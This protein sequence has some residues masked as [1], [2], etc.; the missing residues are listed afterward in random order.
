MGGYNYVII[1]SGG[2]GWRMAG[3]RSE[4]A[5]IHYVCMVYKLAFWGG[6]VRFRLD[7]LRLYIAM[8]DLFIH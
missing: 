8:S 4:K 7:K 6:F 2:G 5:S 1:D 3:F